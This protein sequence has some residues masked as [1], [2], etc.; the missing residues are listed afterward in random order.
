[1]IE[2]GD[3]PQSVPRRSAEMLYPRLEEGEGILWADA[4]DA[5]GAA[6]R[7]MPCFLSGVVMFLAFAAD[8]LSALAGKYFSTIPSVLKLM[9]MDSRTHAWGRLLILPGSLILMICP[10]LSSLAA[11]GT[12]YAVT[13]RR[14]CA[15]RT[16]PFRRVLRSAAFGSFERPLL[17][18]HADG[19]GDILFTPRFRQNAPREPSGVQGLIRIRNAPAVHA[20]ISEQMDRREQELVRGILGPDYL[21]M[22]LKWSERGRDVATLFEDLPG[23]GT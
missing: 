8:P 5:A 21:E 4:P 23:E 14:V 20:I 11:R 22:L 16:G 18:L 13:D 3:V 19:S 9:G 10:F 6:R 12:V 15:L 17:I 2:T 1:M 7:R